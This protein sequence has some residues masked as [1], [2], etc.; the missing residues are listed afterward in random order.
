MHS[1][2]LLSHQQSA[3]AILSKLA[4]I[5]T[6]HLAGGTAVALHLG[7]RES[8]DFDFFREDGFVPQQLVEAFPAPP[9]VLVLQSEANTLTVEFRGVKTSFFGYP[10]PLLRPTVAGPH[11]IEVADLADIAPMKLAAI[12]GRGA[13]KD[14]V[15][16]YFICRE[17]FPLREA[18]TLLGARFPSPQYDLYHLLRSLTYFSDAE[19]EPM[20]ALR[21]PADWEQIK[22]FFISE[23]R[24]LR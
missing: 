22:R 14:F 17:C 8:V 24:R 2:I 13:R 15:D 7:H 10:H 20:P 11:G 21:R 23:A 18:V 19:A 1:E 9:P 6:F 5:R 3:L 4:A 16:L 12:A